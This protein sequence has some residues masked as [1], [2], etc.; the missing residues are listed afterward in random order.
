MANSFSDRINDVPKSFIREILK[1]TIDA[2]IISFAGGLP[3]R[4][5]FPVNELRQAAH[6]V[7]TEAGHDILQYA[8]SEGYLGLRQFIA[9][10][11][12][13]QEG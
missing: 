4:R 9:D 1:V 6:D 13:N 7:F 5:F 11:Y 10:R 12:R 3:N 2:S 8:N